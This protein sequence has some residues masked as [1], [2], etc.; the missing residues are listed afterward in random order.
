MSDKAAPS[1]PKA[2]APAEGGAVTARRRK[3]FTIRFIK[4]YTHEDRT[5]HP[6]RRLRKHGEPGYKTIAADT[7]AVDHVWADHLIKLGV[8]E[9]V[10]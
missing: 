4:E 5:Y 2:A 6:E 9:E 10:K 1:E 7:L 3:Q 8:A